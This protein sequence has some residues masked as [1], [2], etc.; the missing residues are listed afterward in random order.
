MRDY[1]TNGQPHRN[2]PSLGINPCFLL[3][4]LLSLQ[5]SVQIELLYDLEVPLLGTY[6]DRLKPG[7]QTDIEH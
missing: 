7:T 5:K 3:L 4:S 2:A 6:P 1:V